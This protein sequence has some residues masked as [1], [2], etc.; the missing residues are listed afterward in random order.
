MEGSV[1][2]I[3][4]AI[5]RDTA[6]LI[7]GSL[8]IAQIKSYGEEWRLLPEVLIK[9]VGI[10]PERIV[11]A[12]RGKNNNCIPHAFHRLD[13]NTIRELMHKAHEGTVE[14]IPIKLMI[15]AV[16]VFSN[17]M[18]VGRCLMDITQRAG[19]FDSIAVSILIS[20]LSCSE[21]NR[22]YA[23]PRR[24]ANILTREHRRTQRAVVQLHATTKGEL[25]I[26]NDLFITVEAEA[27]KFYFLIH[28]H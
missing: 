25:T 9:S 26:I 2:A 8:I 12:I 18:L 22:R 13:S 23:I 21:R 1:E 24:P 7:V 14:I 19:I 15:C 16:G 27:L 3:C 11:D 10:L 6:S 4:R 28:N 17:E 5:H 20:I